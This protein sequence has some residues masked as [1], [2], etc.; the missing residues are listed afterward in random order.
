M[1]DDNDDEMNRS[2]SV[3]AGENQ[4][5]PEEV[6]P[7]R[8][9]GSSESCASSLALASPT[10]NLRRSPLRSVSLILLVNFALKLLLKECLTL[11]T[12]SL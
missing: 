2:T 3:A 6:D 1:S 12:L 8:H 11:V 10:V 9:L 5:G 4:L 7:P